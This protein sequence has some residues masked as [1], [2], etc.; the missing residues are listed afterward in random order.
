MLLFRRFIKTWY[1][2]TCRFFFNTMCLSSGFITSELIYVSVRTDLPSWIWR[3]TFYPD[4]G[5]LGH[6][7]YFG[8]RPA[9]QASICLVLLLKHFASRSSD[10]GGV[11]KLEPWVA[12]PPIYGRDCLKIKTT[13]RKIALEEEKRDSWI[14]HLNPWTFSP[15][16]LWIHFFTQANLIFSNQKTLMNIFILHY[17][18]ICLYIPQDVQV[19][20]IL[21]KVWSIWRELPN[22]GV[23]VITWYD[24]LILFG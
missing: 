14:H 8:V 18:Y 4:V 15:M 21:L 20:Q 11:A 3:W 2:F 9:K 22:G 5:I 19:S 1:D 17:C 12:I 24:L 23:V 13:R 10:F 16:I 7:N 6:S